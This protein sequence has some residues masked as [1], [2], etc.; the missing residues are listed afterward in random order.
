MQPKSRNMVIIAGC[1]FALLVFFL[2]LASTAQYKK[3]MTKQEFSSSKTVHKPYSQD[4]EDLN[5]YW[6][7]MHAAA[8]YFQDGQFNQAKE[9]IRMAIEKSRYSGDVWMARDILRKIYIQG[10]ERDLALKE[11]DWLYENNPRSDVRKE[12]TEEKTRILATK[13]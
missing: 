9:S 8:D 7:H 6:S 1:A 11:I 12:L 10:G 2:I 3:K 4:I 13:S 5:N